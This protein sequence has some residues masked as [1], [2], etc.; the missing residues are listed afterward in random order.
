MF[1]HIFLIESMHI[2]FPRFIFKLFC[3]PF[4]PQ[5]R[6]GIKAGEPK[7]SLT[8]YT[9]Q[10]LSW[11][12]AVSQGCVF[13]L[14]WVASIVLVSPT[15]RNLVNRYDTRDFFQIILHELQSQ[16]TDVLVQIPCL[17]CSCRNDAHFQPGIMQCV[18]WWAENSAEEALN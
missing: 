14:P 8:N 16:G 15:P 17:R 6:T 9:E 2:K 4:W 10:V 11:K 5:S 7:Q 12:I 1:P 18:C 3:D 13:V